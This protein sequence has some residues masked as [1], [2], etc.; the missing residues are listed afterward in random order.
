MSKKNFTIGA[1]TVICSTLLFSC[2]TEE[3][4]S[5]TNLDGTEKERKNKVDS[6]QQI[7]IPKGMTS[8]KTIYAPGT[9]KSERKKVNG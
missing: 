9:P 6:L 2:V 5:T 1:L 4:I 8:P 3:T 7:T